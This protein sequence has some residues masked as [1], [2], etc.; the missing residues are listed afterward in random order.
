[1]VLSKLHKLEPF[2]PLLKNFFSWNVLFERLIL[3]SII[4]SILLISFYHVEITAKYTVISIHW[5]Y[6]GIL[7][8][9]SWYEYIS[10]RNIWNLCV[11]VICTQI[12]L[13]LSIYFPKPTTTLWTHSYAWKVIRWRPSVAVSY[14][15]FEKNHIH[16]FRIRRLY[17]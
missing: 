13:Q 2:M 9:N 8:Y 5:K 14:S 7:S 12:E 4:L 15:M 3:H 6:A 1:M 17:G 16:W 11:Y 10:Y